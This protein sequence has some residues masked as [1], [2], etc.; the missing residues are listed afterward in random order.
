MQTPR[1]PWVWAELRVGRFFHGCP[2]VPLLGRAQ[3]KGGET[4]RAW[5]LTSWGSKPSVLS[6]VTVPGPHP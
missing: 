4:R 1:S 6:A 3:N 5:F 2:S